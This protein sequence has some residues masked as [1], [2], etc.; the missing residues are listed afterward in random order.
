MDNI[1]EMTQDRGIVT[2]EVL[3]GNCGL[4]VGTD[5]TDLDRQ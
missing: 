2:M 3:I 4:L 5:T 1:S